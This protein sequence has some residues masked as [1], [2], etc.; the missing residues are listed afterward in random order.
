M[1]RRLAVWGSG[2]M[3]RRL[4]VRGSSETLYC[5]CKGCSLDLL[6]FHVFEK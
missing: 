5:C 4:A 6:V 3:A 2:E 1:A